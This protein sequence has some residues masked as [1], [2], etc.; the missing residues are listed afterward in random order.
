[1]HIMPKKKQNDSRSELPTQIHLSHNGN[2]ELAVKSVGM[3]EIRSAN[4]PE[5][6]AHSLAR[7][8]GLSRT[9]AGQML[10]LLCP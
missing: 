4:Y 1:M 3:I 6:S 8:T 9:T 2:A 7:A 5:W 10:A